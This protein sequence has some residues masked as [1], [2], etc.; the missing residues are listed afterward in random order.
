MKNSQVNEEVR[1]I[2]KGL[3]DSLIVLLAAGASMATLYSF[4]HF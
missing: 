2:V 1:F 4:F 3:K